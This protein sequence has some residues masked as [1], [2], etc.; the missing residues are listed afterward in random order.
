MTCSCPRGGRAFLVRGTHRKD[1]C[2][3]AHLRPLLPK[4]SRRMTRHAPTSRQNDLRARSIGERAPAAGKAG[5]VLPSSIHVLPSVAGTV[6]CVSGQ[7]RP[8]V[9]ATDADGSAARV[10]RDRRLP[11]GEE[12]TDLRPRS[13]NAC[14]HG[15]ADAGADA[16]PR[17]SLR[18]RRRA[19]RPHPYG[20]ARGDQER[21]RSRC[22][23][24]LPHLATATARVG[25][26]HD[27]SRPE[28][29]A[30]DIGAD[31]HIESCCQRG[32][33]PTRADPMGTSPSLPPCQADVV[34]RCDGEPAIEA[35]VDGTATL[36]PC[37]HRAGRSTPRR[38]RPWCADVPPKD[39]SGLLSRPGWASGP[40]PIGRSGRGS[41][42]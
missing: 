10:H 13:T 12:W 1:G 3:G 31:P 41:G 2:A 39:P 22:G 26:H 37:R 11:A 32:Q 20:G 27:G 40:E 17:G 23:E 33:T 25:P 6:K 19:S 30:S 4:W 28:R 35:G 8:S 14:C 16:G 7:R 24:V 15:R 36:R 29:N 9:V 42:R 5:S 34:G 21:A 18:R 38:T